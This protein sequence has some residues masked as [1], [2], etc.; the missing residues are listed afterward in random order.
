MNRVAICD[1]VMIGSGFVEACSE[2]LSARLYD[3]NVILNVPSSLC[4]QQFVLT[5][6]VLDK[7]FVKLA[8][9]SFRKIVHIFTMYTRLH[10]KLF[11]SIP[12]PATRHELI[13]S[14]RSS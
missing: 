2:V 10:V 12:K 11:I 8:A 7:T 13:Q 6:I 9:I 3:V 1:C 5:I 14:T 4:H